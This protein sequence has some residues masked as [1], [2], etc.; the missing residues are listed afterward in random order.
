MSLNKPLNKLFIALA[1]IAFATINL[2]RAQSICPPDQRREFVLSAVDKDRKVVDNLQSEHLRLKVGGAP[3]TIADVVF[4]TNV[5][6]DLAVLI[7]TSISQQEMLPASK[8]AARA[9]LASVPVA[10]RD[11]VA[12]VSFSDKPNYL[13]PMSSDFASA[14]T[15]I[16]RIELA[17]PDGYVGGGVVVTARPPKPFP[18]A[19]TT[20]LWDVVGA[21]TTEVFAAKTEDRRRVI[22]LFTD[23]SDTA[24]SGQLN[25]VIEEALQNHVTIFSIGFGN[26]GDVHKGSL[27]KLSEQTGGIAEFPSTSK[28]K[29]EIALTRIAR[30]LR[31]NY[32]VGYCGGA[33]KDRAKIELE[34]VDPEIRKAK[35][36][37]AYK[38]Y[39]H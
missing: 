20:S 37:L 31:G 18:R 28:K 4:Q 30:H 8:A 32:V 7:D 21:A 13:H 6:L 17:I 2:A 26:W 1:L 19:G 5:P 12:L 38:Q 23:G 24:S 9:F 35:P 36:V 33:A 14:A 22:L 29:L 25:T 16:N 27:K 15:A 3:A 11:R 34:V 39:W 10:G